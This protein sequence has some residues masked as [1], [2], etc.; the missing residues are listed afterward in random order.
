MKAGE[1]RWVWEDTRS[2]K[3]LGKEPLE[4]FL[5]EMKGMHATSN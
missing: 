1:V 3:N 4:M 5:V 2:E